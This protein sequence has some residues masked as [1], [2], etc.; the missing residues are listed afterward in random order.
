MSLQ[1]QDEEITLKNSGLEETLNMDSKTVGL[2]SLKGLDG[3]LICL[4]HANSA[5]RFSVSCFRFASMTLDK[6]W[7]KTWNFDTF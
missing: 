1:L 3:I 5:Q 6:T 7:S 2:G 4:S